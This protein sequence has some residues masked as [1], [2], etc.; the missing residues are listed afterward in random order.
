MNRSEH[1]MRRALL[2]L[3]VGAGLLLSVGCN[4]LKARDNLNK[5]VQAYKNARYEEAI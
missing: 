1:N 4:K 3:L 2:V 5:G